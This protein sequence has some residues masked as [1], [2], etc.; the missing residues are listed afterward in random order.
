MKNNIKIIISIVLSFIL[1]FSYSVESLALSRYGS[2]G[3]EV[4]EIQRRLKKWDYYKGSVDGIYG[5]KT[6]QAVIK[7][8]KRNGLTADGVAGKR[9]LEKMQR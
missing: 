5:T 3:A 4:K 7:F 1:I 9:T 6:K 8:Q 2:R